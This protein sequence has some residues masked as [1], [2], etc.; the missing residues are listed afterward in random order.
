MILARVCSVFFSHILMLSNLP[1]WFEI[2]FS[3]LALADSIRPNTTLTL[4]W[5]KHLGVQ[6]SMIT[7]DNSRTAAAVRNKLGLDQFVSEMKPKDKLLWIQNKQQNK[8]ETTG[9]LRYNGKFGF[10]RLGDSLL[11]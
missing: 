3:H 9:L 2:L 8:T 10:G 6:T 11:F 4:N 1:V 7:G 5:L